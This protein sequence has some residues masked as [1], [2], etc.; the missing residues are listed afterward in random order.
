MKRLW[1]WVMAV[2]VLLPLGG[3]GQEWV[4]SRESTTPL[5]AVIAGD[6]GFLAGG[7][8]STDAL[9]RSPDGSKWFKVPLGGVRTIQ[10]IA[11]TVGPNGRP[12][13]VAVDA[14]GGVLRSEA[15]EGPWVE[16]A[17]AR[18]G[19]NRVASRSGLFVACGV[20]GILLES[21]DA[22]ITWKEIPSPVAGK[23]WRFLTADGGVRQ[24]G[25]IWA[26][27]LM[28][29][30][31]GTAV[32]RD[33]D[34]R[35]TTLS[36]L[37]SIVPLTGV[38]WFNDHFWVFGEGTPVSWAGRFIAV[39]VP[40]SLWTS[41]VL[42]PFQSSARYRAVSALG[43]TAYSFGDSGLI[44]S[45]PAPGFP[46]LEN[47]LVPGETVGNFTDSSVGRFGIAAV[48]DL[49]HVFRLPTNT[50]PRPE[51]LVTIRPTRTLLSEGERLFLEL[52]VAAPDKVVQSVQ[53]L[54][55]SRP[56]GGV[57]PTV[58]A[59]ATW[60]LKSAV[61]ASDS[62]F[63]RAEVV[64]TDG[65]RVA[66]ESGIGIHVEPRPALVWSPVSPAAGLSNVLTGLALSRDRLLIGGESGL[67]SSSDGVRW[68]PVSS[69]DR[70][71]Y[72]LDRINGICF[73]LGQ[74]L[75]AR[76]TNGV[77]WVPGRGPGGD[78]IGGEFFGVLPW[79][80]GYLAFGG[81]SG[82]GGVVLF[83]KDG[84]GWDLDSRL[85]GTNYWF[86]G[87]TDGRILVLGGQKGALRRCLP[88]GSVQEVRIASGEDIYSV[89]A[90]RGRFLAVTESGKLWASTDG[91]TW[92]LKRD[93]GFQAYV[94][95]QRGSLLFVLGSGGSGVQWTADGEVWTPGAWNGPAPSPDFGD[96]VLVEGVYRLV[97][98]TGI[99]GTSQDLGDV[100]TPV[101]P[102]PSVRQPSPSASAVRVE[103][104]VVFSET[105]E[106]QWWLDGAVI[107]GVVG[108]I[109]ELP[110]TDWTQERRIWVVVRWSQGS[111]PLGPFR[112]VPSRPEPF[113]FTLNTPGGTLAA[114]SDLWV[115][116]QGLAI[117]G[118]VRVRVSIDLD[119][120]G[121]RQPT[122]P[123]VE[124]FVVKDGIL[125]SIGGVRAP[126]Q[127]GDED[128]EANGAIDCR[129][130][131]SQPTEFEA[132]SLS[133]VVECELPGLPGSSG[134]MALRTEVRT[135]PQGVEG[136]VVNPKTGLP[137]PFAMVLAF[138][139]E[140]LQ[141]V[142]GVVAD[143][144][145]RYRMPCPSGGFWIVALRDGFV[146]P[147]DPS[148]FLG[149]LAGGDGLVLPG[150][151]AHRVLHLSPA[152]AEIEGRILVSNS[153]APIGDEMLLLV[154]QEGIALGQISSGGTWR[155]RVLGGEWRVHNLGLGSGR[156][157]RM[158]LVGSS[159]QD[160]R[161]KVEKGGVLRDAVIRSQRPDRLLRVAV[162]G[163]GPRPLA[164]AWV[165]SVPAN[166]G[167]D[168]L[169]GA[170]GRADNDG[171]AWL[172]LP[173]GEQWI[174]GMFVSGNQWFPAVE[175]NRFVLADAKSTQVV[176][177]LKAEPRPD[178]LIRFLS[179]ENRCCGW[180]QTVFGAS[181]DMDYEVEA[182]SD[183]IG[184][185][186][187]ATGSTSGHLG[188]FI[189]GD[190]V[191]WDKRFYRIRRRGSP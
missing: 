161:F 160:Q 117:S 112:I 49:G 146:S 124:S 39:D 34:G 110:T 86:G 172:G 101:V 38:E 114:G 135:D 147:I 92:V 162:T 54:L 140:G 104:P 13:Y 177:D 5:R 103:V 25:S 56:I 20:D 179:I 155:A 158:S 185:K 170:W 115:K 15:P 45:G 30:D 167:A 89:A 32:C 183:L 29:A 151:F 50:P 71:V 16:V 74:E 129:I 105:V 57:D 10:S 180:P 142:S 21:V 66:S 171:I 169:W 184:W 12:A 53:W 121:R 119:G 77:D 136:V 17:Q 22:G 68:S 134:S 26:G 1:F 148:A 75:I 24:A 139:P 108:S 174:G 65:T 84:I 27:F 145:G 178:A 67:S 70:P 36:S 131:W 82:V 107:P 6:F 73:A 33:L 143:A 4:D 166:P 106:Y 87:G 182:S 137:V 23:S 113:G 125:P 149:G 51:I 62:G 31:D 2:G 18:G 132:L 72:W 80:G 109:L 9:L 94:F 168:P 83:S 64:F 48:T 187:I 138:Q 63:Y 165:S 61:T 41:L 144:Q 7:G 153:P 141:P 90:F 14:S 99:V 8:P 3:R 55:D 130:A 127:P 123:V 43:A 116:I 186:V 47:I 76:S 176:L 91:L 152:D 157:G 59:T 96:V 60:Y 164:G 19:L 37:R 118:E 181:F 28:L 44:R 46:G 159:A 79:G 98:P 100:E 163:P 78:P 85:A 35:W 69:I 95:R 191:L 128:H 150:C 188:A 97:G 120:D 88:D 173:A 111:L 93:L 81:K 11:T 156:M 190:S 133:Y 52:D 40:I 189:D 102:E 58:P 126:A 175:T 42:P 154:G 122:E